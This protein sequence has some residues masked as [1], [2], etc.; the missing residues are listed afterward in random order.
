MKIFIRCPN[1]PKD[2][3]IVELQGEVHI[4]GLPEGFNPDGLQFA[5]IS[6]QN[7]RYSIKHRHFLCQ[8]HEKSNSLAE[9][10]QGKA[11]LKV[12]QHELRG[13]SVKLEK[14]LAVLKKVASAHKPSIGT[15]ESTSPVSAASKSAYEIVGVVRH[16]FLFKDR[17]KVLL[18]MPAI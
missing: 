5:D 1:A 10:R 6:E 9:S 12:G 4:D 7:V 14:P 2:W 8:Q 13:S 11:V 3:Y 18:E 16:K 15:E 17:P